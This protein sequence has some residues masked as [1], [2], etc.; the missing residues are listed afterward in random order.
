MEETPSFYDLIRLIEKA[1]DDKN[2]E[3][4]LLKAN[5]NANGFGNS[6]EIRNALIDFKASKNSS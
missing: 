5:G 3:G 1:K 6:D 4:I 2:I